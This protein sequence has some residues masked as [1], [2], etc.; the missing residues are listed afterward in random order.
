VLLFTA[1]SFYSSYHILLSSAHIIFL[2]FDLCLLTM[3][4]T[5]IRV[6][7]VVPVF[8]GSSSFVTR[9]RSISYARTLWGQFAKIREM[10]VLL[11]FLPQFLSIL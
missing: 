8:F 7:S 6:F 2:F 10:A 11:I 3:S 4:Y 1:V 5:F 9:A